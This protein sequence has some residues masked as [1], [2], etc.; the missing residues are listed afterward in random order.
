MENKKNNSIFIFYIYNFLINTRFSRGVLLLYCLKLG[1]SVAEFGTIQSAYSLIKMLAEIPTGIL[2]DRF[3]K[4]K[5][6][7]LGTLICSVSSFFLFFA[8]NFFARPSFYLI[9]LLFSLDSLGGALNSGTDQAML[10]EYL[11]AEKNEDKFIKI[12]GNAQI[13]GLIV[14]AISTALGGKVFSFSFSTVFLLQFIFYLLAGIDILFF[15]TSSNMVVK[16]EKVTNSIVT[17]IRISIS[18]LQTK[19]IIAIIIVF[20][21]LFEVFVNS[22]VTFIP[23][24][25]LDIGFNDTTIAIIIGSV[26]LV[27]VAGSYL[28]RYL[29][30][31][32]FQQFLVIFSLLFITTSAL[33]ATNNKVMVLLGFTVINL[34]LDAAYPYISD[35]INK[36]V[37]E[38]VRTTILS[39]SNSL[40]GVISL[41]F[42]PILGWLIDNFGYSISFLST[43]IIVFV[44]MITLIFVGKGIKQEKI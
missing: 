6:L 8:P 41:V 9:L 5:V 29:K 1:L 20:L 11:K 28:S 27:G 16:E 36:S 12:L 3:S 32:R 10:F 40:I 21:T 14:L 26:T 43:G 23:G 4:K 30:N 35:M 31:I 13:I 18:E 39:F 33:I 2:A 34:L 22:L 38:N 19:R 7:G 24:N 25:L 37:K 17:Q 44:I 15:K 42:Y